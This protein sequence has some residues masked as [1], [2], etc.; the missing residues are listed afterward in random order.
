[1]S[2]T[3]QDRVVVNDGVGDVTTKAEGSNAIVFT[4]IKANDS[5]FGLV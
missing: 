2:G 3:D 1:M 5:V 4:Y